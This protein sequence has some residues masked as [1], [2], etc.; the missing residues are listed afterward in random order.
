MP[1]IPAD[2]ELGNASPSING[3][4]SGEAKSKGSRMRARSTPI[5]LWLRRVVTALWSDTKTVCSDRIT[6]VVDLPRKI[7]R[8][9]IAWVLS[10]RL[11]CWMKT[12]YHR[13]E[14]LFPGWEL[15]VVAAIVVAFASL[16]LHIVFVVAV[17]IKFKPRSNGLGTLWEGNC[18]AVDWVNKVVHGLINLLSAI[19][20]GQSNYCMQLLASPT[21][22]EVDFAHKN[23][24]WVDIGIPSFRNVWQGHIAR[25]R[26]ICWL[27]LSFASLP[28]NLLWNSVIIYSPVAYQYNQLTVTDGFVRG[29]P[30]DDNNNNTGLAIIDYATEGPGAVWPDNLQFLQ[31]DLLAYER[32]ENDDC[33][34]KYAQFFITDRSDVIVVTRP[35]TPDSN[36]STVLG[37]AGAGWGQW[38]YQWLCPPEVRQTLDCSKTLQSP[39]NDWNFP[40]YGKPKVEY[41]LSKKME[42]KCKLEY[43]VL[44]GSLTV[45]AIG[46]KFL[47][48]VATYVVLKLNSKTANK[49]GAQIDR[50]MQP[51]VTT[52][53]AIAS[54]LEIEDKTTI[55]M[56]MAEK[57]HFE[58][59]IWDHHWIRIS[60][61]PWRE[62]RP[63][64]RFRA[65]G[66]RRWLVG[67]VILLIIPMLPLWFLV[68]K[69]SWLR[70]D[71]A[72]DIGA[73]RELGLGNPSGLFLFGVWNGDIQTDDSVSFQTEVSAKD[74]LRNI[75]ASNSPQLALALAYFIWNSHIT[76]MI[77]ARE[78]TMYAASTKCMNDTQ[79]HQPKHALRLTYV[80]EGTQQRN[81][82]F[83][84]IPLRY[85]IPITALWTLLQWLASQAVF[86]ARLD[87]LSHWLQVSE[88]S[89]SQVGYSVLGIICFTAVSCVV[90]IS[91]SVLSIKNI[92]N[93][94]PLAATC[95]AALSAACHP[96]DPTLKHFE[97][98][99]H[100]GVEKA[101]DEA[102]TGGIDGREP[103]ERC[104]FTSL[105]ARY[106]TTGSFYA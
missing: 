39:G 30:F 91:G 75:V 74:T 68:S 4:L 1:V 85:W 17:S 99:I 42:K 43:G 48:F 60:P 97:K 10:W 66:V 27:L 81:S 94:M 92:N 105:E 83:F 100:W 102:I 24:K 45:G 58:N 89:I 54:F 93:E 20:I 59:G 62:R 22:K 55:G 82:H 88:Y 52:G 103:L 21:R 8:S 104:T 2:P 77:S 64:S 72:L 73:I 80:R 3:G 46:L 78:Y 70:D 25:Q 38:P 14:A 98:K 28:L 101:D 106:P 76:V 63:C 95:S 56:S 32:L 7:I 6:R 36:R 90:F 16:V 15:G 51:L 61:M 23:R 79:Y 71:L 11:V 53:D 67:M 13:A 44:V 35:S 41:C 19:L 29:L 18:N 37:G 5:F 50:M 57:E 65:I 40:N 26:I 49:S 34:K 31:Q 86:F 84:A 47:L 9:S 33:K 69:Y 87:L 12:V 96:K